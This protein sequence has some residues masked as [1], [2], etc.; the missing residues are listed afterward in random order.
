MI[1]KNKPL[2][3]IGDKKS[4]VKF[5]WFP[6]RITSTERVWLE[7]YIQNYRYQRSPLNLKCFWYETNKSFKNE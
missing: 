1:I 3:E 6:V 7:T 5:A 2:P 4:K